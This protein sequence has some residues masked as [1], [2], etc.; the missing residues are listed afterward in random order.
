MTT[1]HTTAHHPPPSART[2]PPRHPPHRHTATPPHHAPT[3]RRPPA[4]RSPPTPS[5]HRRPLRNLN[6][7]DL[8]E[9]K[10]CSSG[11]C[12]IVALCP[13]NIATSGTG[14]FTSRLAARR[15]GTR[16]NG[17]FCPASRCSLP[18]PAPS[19]LLTSMGMFNE[20]R[21]T[22]SS[23]GCVPVGRS[24]FIFPTGH[25]AR[26]QAAATQNKGARM[27]STGN[28]SVCPAS[29]LTRAIGFCLRGRVVG[30]GC[31]ADGFLVGLLCA[32]ILALAARALDAAAT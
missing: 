14:N 18:L 16:Q 4:S 2:P 30:L 8:K 13:R 10:L 32:S 12:G 31:S 26:P 17:S 6:R 11:Y 29:L 1:L 5:L 15:L 3:L 22:L 7:K 27:A 25:T 20:D 19:F 24:N 23:V 9:N 28:V 21:L